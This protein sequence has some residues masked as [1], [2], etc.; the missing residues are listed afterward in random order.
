VHWWGSIRCTF[1][2]MVLLGRGI[3]REEAGGWGESRG[4]W[5]S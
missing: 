4:G 3:G 1:S 5:V 2:D